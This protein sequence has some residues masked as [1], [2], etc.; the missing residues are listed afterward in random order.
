MLLG[1]AEGIPNALCV[2]NFPEGAHGAYIDAL[3]A[4]SA[5][6]FAEAVSKGRPHCGL[7][8][9]VDQAKYADLLDLTANGY[10][11]AAKDALI[12]VPHDGWRR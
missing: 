5:V 12:G 6:D 2:I 7:K 8:T 9:P 11:S 10:A 1:I 3:T 4:V